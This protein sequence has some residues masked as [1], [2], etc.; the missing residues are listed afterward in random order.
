M[1]VPGTKRA[2]GSCPAG[3]MADSRGSFCLN[4]AIYQ[5]LGQFLVVQVS[6]PPR[7]SRGTPAGHS[8]RFGEI[9]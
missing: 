5:D 3:C 4:L 9:T 8:L 1:T 6:V 2:S 7:G